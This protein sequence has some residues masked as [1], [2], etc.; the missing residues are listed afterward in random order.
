MNTHQS[1]PTRSL[2]SNAPLPDPLKRK[3]TSKKTPADK[4]ATTSSKKLPTAPTSHRGCQQKKRDERADLQPPIPVLETRHG[5]GSP[6]PNE[7]DGPEAPTPV[8]PT[9]TSTSTAPGATTSTT[10]PTSTPA[11]TTSTTAP[12]STMAPT[13][14]TTTLTPTTTATLTT[15]MTSTTVGAFSTVNP[16]TSIAATNSTATGTDTSTTVSADTTTASQFRFGGPAIQ[17]GSQK[18][19]PPF[20]LF[21]P[22]H[23]NLLPGS[24]RFAPPANE[25][26]R[27]TLFLPPDSWQQNTVFGPLGLHTDDSPHSPNEAPTPP[28]PP[29][30]PTPQQLQ[31]TPPTQSP[32]PCTPP[33]QSPP[34][35]TP[36]A[37]SLLPHTPPAQSPLPHTPPGTKSRSRSRSRSRSPSPPTRGNKGKAKAPAEP[38][39]TLQF[40][41]SHRDH[42]PELPT[43]PAPAARRGKGEAVNNELALKREAK[44]EVLAALR[45]DVLEVHRQWNNVAKD[46]AQRHHVGVDDVH[47]MLR[48]ES[49]WGSIKHRYNKFNAK[50]WRRGQEL[51]AGKGPGER[52]DMHAIHDI[53]NSEPE[54][55]W[56]TNDLK[57][58]RK[59]YLA[60]KER[61]EKGTRGSN[62]DAAK[63]VTS[64]GDKF[65]EEIQRL[66]QRTGASAFVV[67]AGSDVNDTIRPAII[68]SPKTAR[69]L[70]E[71]LKMPG[72][73]LAQCLHRWATLGD[74]VKPTKSQNR[75]AE[76][77]TMLVDSLNAMFDTSTLKMEYTHY[78]NRV[79]AG[80]GVQLVGWPQGV[81]FAA[82]STLGTGGAAAIDK[83]W[84]VLKCKTLHWEDIPTKAHDALLEEYPLQAK[85]WKTWERQRE[86]ARVKAKA[87]GL[88]DG[89]A[90]D[91]P[92]MKKKKRVEGEKGE[93]EGNGD[94][95]GGATKGKKRKQAVEVVEEG[96]KGEGEGPEKKKKKKQ[97]VEAGEEDVERVVG[98]KE[99]K[100]KRKKKDAVEVATGEKEPEK[101][102]KR[103]DGSKGD[104]EPPQ[105]KVAFTHRRTTEERARAYKTPAIVPSSDEEENEAPHTTKSVDRGPLDPNHPRDKFLLDQAKL[106]AVAAASRSSSGI[107]IASL[108]AKPV[109][110]GSHLSGAIA[111]KVHHKKRTIS[112]VAADD[113]D[114]ETYSGSN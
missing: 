14:S 10:A 85:N 107:P 50:T 96:D 111:K 57:Q 25:L 95:D 9:S 23:S 36:P 92:K 2:R 66:E 51:N 58:L 105:K 45:V 26:P 64:M 47:E 53:I 49:T 67:I 98:D 106:E 87:A 79:R 40:L 61:E 30:S 46:L 52:L 32:L 109:A 11:P 54:G 73:A 41:G 99:R 4:K 60:Y 93:G 90:A 44:K 84:E 78:D 62:R 110:S 69:F 43:Q 21:G 74:D 89:P 94:G 86:L 91:V 77:V 71:V 76:V 24:S 56:S 33:A 37:Q 113:A 114:D 3:D 42:H 29:R 70:P 101:K 97:A 75:R 5:T 82:P 72:D 13:T 104:E 18:E 7:R 102:R 103:R 83:L 80:M 8:A 6:E 16:T 81:A 1:Q 65:L 31:H 59:D 38:D 68:V 35:H 28:L 12:T 17:I 34:P 55:T 39:P 20:S 15:S 112:E 19:H 100:K 22:P 108:S 48:S 88:V 27:S 63:D